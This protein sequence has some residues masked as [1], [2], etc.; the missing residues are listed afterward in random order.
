MPFR[1]LHTE[2]SGGWAGQER[3]V[4]LECE[5]MR[6]RGH[7]LL[8]AGEANAPLAIEARNRG[9][10]V[11]EL[12][13]RRGLDL[14]A[15]RTVRRLVRDH[16]IEIINSHSSKDAWV[17]GLAAR[18]TGARVVR[19]R[20]L[21]IPVKPNARNRLLYTKLTHHLVTTGEALRQQL[22]REN[23]F[24]PDRI[25]SVPTGV[26][27]QRFDP[28]TVT[29]ASLHADYGLPAEAR[30]IGV[31]AMLRAMKGHA[32]LIEALPG[33]LVEHPDVCVLFFG[34]APAESPLPAQYARRADELGIAQRL[35]FCGYR[36][37]VPPVLA[38]LD[39]VVQPSI[40]DEGVPQ[41]ITQALAMQRPVVAT[42]IGATGEV[43]RNE[44][45]GLLVP[46]NDVVALADA[47]NR[48]L[49]HPDEAEK[50]ARAGRE[51]IERE[52]S[53]ARM[54][55]RMEAVYAHVLGRVDVA[56]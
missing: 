54:A 21:S 39:C 6:K 30:L 32:V 24:A 1:V 36:D 43:V 18:G 37:D 26:D 38:A 49:A 2:C 42:D 4:L 14:A 35:R 47:V 40:R 19:T 29:P 50:R 7:T 22:V 52:Y 34:E 3:R 17:A 33:I 31:L 28:V 9:F 46:P 20:H 25:S 5:E 48:V 53:A 51:L 8:L 10:E 44:E 45:T 12:R 56:A 55:E 41:S 16:Q 13:Y 27:L 11:H 15:I 23:G